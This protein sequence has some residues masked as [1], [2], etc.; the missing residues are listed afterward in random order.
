MDYNP[1]IPLDEL[2]N[3]VLK[4]ENNPLS[5][6]ANASSLIYHYFT[7]LNWTGFYYLKEKLNEEILLYLG[8]FQG[9]VACNPIKYGKGVCG[10]SIK[11]NKIQI[12]PNVHLLTNHIECDSNSQSEY[13]FPIYYKEDIFGVLDI[14]SPII[15]RFTENEITLLTNVSKVISKLISNFNL[16]Q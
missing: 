13:V 14:D 9:R 16:L 3:V 7:D 11:E 1:N 15:A 6:F 2:L 4:D 5:F 12:V 10:S 8:P